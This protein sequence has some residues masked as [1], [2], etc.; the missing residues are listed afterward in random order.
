MARFAQILEVF[1]DLWRLQPEHAWEAYAVP[2]T[3]MP[4]E[5]ELASIGCPLPLESLP[6]TDRH[7]GAGVLVGFLEDRD[8]SY[9]GFFFFCCLDTFNRCSL[10][11]IKLNGPF[12]NSCLHRKNL[13]GNG[14][15]PFGL[16]QTCRE[17]QS[18]A[19][20]FFVFC[21]SWVRAALNSSGFCPLSRQRLCSGASVNSGMSSSLSQ[22][23]HPIFQPL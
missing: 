16:S 12:P 19:S 20:S 11:F 9:L 17:G 4:P 13:Q 1:I 10:F 18:R 5:G 8:S 15:G 3:L 7:G 2:T 14:S 22:A 23:P 21:T 6:V